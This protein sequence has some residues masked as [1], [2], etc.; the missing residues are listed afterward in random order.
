MASHPGNAGISGWVWA[1]QVYYISFPYPHLHFNSILTRGNTRFI[2]NYIIYY[3]R[4]SHLLR[5]EAICREKRPF[6]KKGG[7]SSREGE[8]V[9]QGKEE[10]VHWGKT[11]LWRDIR[12]GTMHQMP[13]GREETVHWEGGDCVK[14]EEIALRGRRPCWEGGDRV[15]REETTLRG[16]RPRQGGGDHIKGEETASR[17]RRPRWEGGHRVERDETASRGR[18]PHRM[19]G[20]HIEREATICWGREG[21]C[22]SSLRGG[23]LY[24]EGGRRLREVHWGRRLE[25][26]CPSREGGNCPSRVRRP[27][28][29]W[30]RE[31]TVRRE[32][33]DSPA[34]EGDHPSREAP[35]GGSSK[36]KLDVVGRKNNEFPCWEI[37]KF[38]RITWCQ[39]FNGLEQIIWFFYIE[40][41]AWHLWHLRHGIHN[42]TNRNYILKNQY[43]VSYIGLAFEWNLVDILL[44]W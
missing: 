27:T 36:R 2:Y 7:H 11:S 41:R 12:R 32:G 31:E 9:R 34:R 39:S 14:R 35:L 40:A 5:E 38:N 17:G 28:V 19:G 25:A 21:P 37:Q 8:T 18:R 4:A 1:A 15:E 13:R 30:G 6:I 23:Q 42:W 43:T 44:L 33:W 22:P 10:A 24:V 26:I 29:C 3:P 16:R 20:D